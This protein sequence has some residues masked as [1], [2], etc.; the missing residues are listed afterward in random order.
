VRRRAAPPG[1]ARRAFAPG[2]LSSGTMFTLNPPTMPQATT[3]RLVRAKDTRHSVSG[4]AHV[5]LQRHMMHVSRVH[6]LASQLATDADLLIE[7]L[8]YFT[9]MPPRRAAG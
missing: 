3:L 2:V 6:S 7:A 1:T 5:L 4:A 8:R 9:V